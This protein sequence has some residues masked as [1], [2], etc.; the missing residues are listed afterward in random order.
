MPGGDGRTT[1]AALWEDST[2]KKNKKKT[3]VRLCLAVILIQ[4]AVRGSEISDHRDGNAAVEALLRLSDA[5]RNWRNSGGDRE[6]RERP[7]RPGQSELV[8][9]FAGSEAER[10]LHR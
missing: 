4:P 9:V 1:K 8:C 6:R 5:E 7:R 10:K 2:K 3:L